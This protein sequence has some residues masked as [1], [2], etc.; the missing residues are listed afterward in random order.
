MPDQVEADL[1]AIVPRA[2]LRDAHHWLI[3][4]GR[5]VC[6]ARKPRCE[7]CVLVDLC[8]SRDLFI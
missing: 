6:V 8:P 1:M 7:I 5:Y 2:Y 3:L 4:Q